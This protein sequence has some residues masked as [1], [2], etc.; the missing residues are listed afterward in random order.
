MAASGVEK[1][2]KKKTE[3]KLAAREEAKLLAGFMGVMN[4]M[5]KQKTLCDV[6]LMVQER[7]IPAHRVVLAAASHFFNLMFTTN[8]LE[9]KSFEVEL[10]D[11][12]PDIIEQLVEFAYTA[13]ISVN[14]N[15]VQSLLDAANQYQ[16]EPVKKMC[17][18][19]LKEQVDASNC[20]G[21]AEKVNQS[22][23][24]CDILF[25]KR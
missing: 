24:E 7:K 16:I 18:D 13:R 12:E 20:L 9:S 4:N 17:V 2:S 5:R 1:S 11:A 6:I 22:F 23:P 8:M 14:S 25:T 10:K 3:K 19:F 15:N 21:E